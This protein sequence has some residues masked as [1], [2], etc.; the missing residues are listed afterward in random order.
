MSNWEK[1]VSLDINRYKKNKL[2][3][4][5]ALLGLVFNCLYFMLLYGIKASTAG[6]NN[7]VTWFA[8][9][10][11]GFS[12]ILTLIVLLVSFLASEG[13]KGYNKKYAYVLWVLAAFQIFKIFGY[14]LYGLQNDLLQVNYFWLNPTESVTEF[15]ILVI[16]LVASAGCYVASGVIGYLRAIDLEKFV[17]AIEKGDIDVEASLKEAE[18]QENAVASGNVSVA[19]E[20]VR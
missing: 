8:N 12:V 10:T 9:I 17:L 6:E 15:V 4:N 2:A 20:E 7:D 5:L 14:P 1:V 16:Y 3:A 18:E 13:I 11:M 19:S